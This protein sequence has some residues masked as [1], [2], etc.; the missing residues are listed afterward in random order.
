MTIF[1]LMLSFTF[2][3]NSTLAGEKEIVVS[4]PSLGR[5]LSLV[6]SRWRTVE[7]KNKIIDRTLTTEGPE[8]VLTWGDGQE[9]T[10]DD[11]ACLSVDSNSQSTTA[12]LENK[13][14][15]LQA[16]ITYSI[17][18][19]GQPWFYKQIKLL[20]GGGIKSLNNIAVQYHLYHEIKPR[21]QENLDL[22]EKIKSEK[23][24]FTPSGI[25]KG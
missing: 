5:I 21:P 25:E 20:F 22:F 14:L 9:S 13:T 19:N 16:E 3:F 23:Q 15:H 12:K 18:S 4:N 10:S 17:A 7:V 24:Y 2:C 8:F 11:F 1:L 6:D